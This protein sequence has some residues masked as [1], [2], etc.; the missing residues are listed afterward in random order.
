MHSAG[1]NVTQDGT[2]SEG[3][4]VWTPI[5][6]TEA[7]RVA[8]NACGYIRFDLRAV[9]GGLRKRATAHNSRTGSQKAA[10]GK[11]VKCL[12]SHLKCLSKEILT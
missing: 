10:A 1:R 3:R 11:R 5:K 6:R 4:K 8:L 9:R 2:T 7:G 12:L